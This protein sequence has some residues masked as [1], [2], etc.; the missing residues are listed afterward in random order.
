MHVDPVAAVTH[1]DP[2]P[3]YAEL[4]EGPALVW[5]DKLRLWVASRADVIESVLMVRCGCGPPSSRSRAPSRAVSPAS[6]SVIWCA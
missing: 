5:N 1:A 4:R 3:F 2:Y 6:C